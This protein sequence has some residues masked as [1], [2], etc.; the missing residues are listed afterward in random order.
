MQDTR[1]GRPIQRWFR[2]PCNH[3]P[4]VPRT[5]QVPSSHRLLAPFDLERPCLEQC[6]KGPHDELPGELHSRRPKPRAYRSI[7]QTSNASISSAGASWIS[8]GYAWKAG[9]RHRGSAFLSLGTVTVMGSG[10]AIAYRTVF[11]KRLRQTKPPGQE[12]GLK[13][14]ISVSHQQKSYRQKWC[15]A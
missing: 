8:E 6:A 1:T 4:R 11:C 5:Q 13:S 12:D 14:R 2:R 3:R 9:F 10:L 15:T 7:D